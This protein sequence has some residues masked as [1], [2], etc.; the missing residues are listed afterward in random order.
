MVLPQVELRVPLQEELMVLPQE[1]LR[2]LP[3]V[4]LR[5]PLQEELMVRCQLSQTYPPKEIQVGFRQLRDS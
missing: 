3:Q 2:V 5:V 1:E 4:E